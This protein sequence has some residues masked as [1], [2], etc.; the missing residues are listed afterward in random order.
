[1]SG[2][3]TA[4]P[5]PGQSVPEAGRISAAHRVF[6]DP[7]MRFLARRFGRLTVS[8]FVLVTAAFLMIHLVPGDPVRAALGLSAPVELVEARREALGL[9]DPIFVQYGN[10]LAGLVNGDLG[11]SMFSNQ[12]VAGVIADRLPNTALLGGLAFVAVLTIAIPLGLGMA[13]VTRAGRRRG[14]ELGFT[15]TGA[16]MSAIPEFLVGVAL[17]AVFG[18]TLGWFPV[19]GMSG[20]TSLVL[21]VLALS[22]GPAM[23]LARIL[24]VE[25]LRVLSEDFVR[26]A[27]AKRLPR[28]VI[29]RRHVFPN[30]L[31]SMVTI[32]G[33]LLSAMIIGTV[34]VENVFAWPGLGMTIVGSILQKDYPLVQGIVLVYGAAVLLVNLLVDVLLAITDPRSTIRES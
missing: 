12:S 1:V 8:L 10:Y 30:A 24:R 32:G 4:R 18:V 3:L 27:R 26:T 20:G 15:A 21:P 33:L 28:R 6:A 9:N 16:V 29:N 14:A 11:T 17:V 13:V 19:A 34:L 7:W 23:A 31:T 2:G 22:L 5:A 25:A